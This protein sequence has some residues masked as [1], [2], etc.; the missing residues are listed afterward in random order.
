MNLE[1]FDRE[2]K[3]LLSNYAAAARRAEISNVEAKSL[4][5][6]VCDGDPTLD[7]CKIFLVGYNPA[8]T[9]RDDN[10]QYIDWCRHWNS[11]TGYDLPGFYRDYIRY[12]TGRKVSELSSVSN[13]VRNE[14]GRVGQTRAVIECISS[15]L[16][17]R[18][19]P[20]GGGNVRVLET[21]LFWPPTPCDEDLQDSFIASDS[22][23][24]LMALV[25]MLE[26][27]VIIGHHL[28]SEAFLE[29]QTPE[30]SRMGIQLIKLSEWSP[31]P[32]TLKGWNPCSHLRSFPYKAN[33]Q[34]NR[35][36]VTQLADTILKSLEASLGV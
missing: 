23:N 2:L 24:G 30:L 34:G 12:R 4:R 20:S 11:K 32:E 14:P 27:K 19:F 15:E 29:S 8:T 36:R 1:Q 6:F 3:A 18:P 31:P 10:E 7:T 22:G 17:Q 26:P 35:P 5:P 21:N 33:R 9:L 25:R 13:R 16:A 28:R